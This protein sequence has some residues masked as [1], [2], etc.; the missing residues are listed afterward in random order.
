MTGMTEQALRIASYNVRA[1]LGTDLRRDPARSLAVIDA[2]DPDLI[3]LQEADFRMGVRPTAL[4]RGRIAELT[5]LVPVPVGGHP[6]SLGWHG[7]ALLTRPALRVEA[8]TCIDLPGLEPRGAVIADLATALGP[9][10]VAGVHLGL[11]RRSRRQQLDHLRL[12]LGAMAQRPTL[13]LGD[14]NEWSL[15]RGLGRIARDFRIVT[16]GRSFPSNRPL[17]ALDRI[18]HSP[19]LAVSPLPLPRVPRGPQPSDHLPIL[20]ELRRSAAT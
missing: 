15:R 8:V 13:I 20:A 18:A 9:L 6:D 1:G 16:P 14:F 12:T 3:V 5:A 11:L 19:D 10:R 2:L 17:L 7:I 4:P